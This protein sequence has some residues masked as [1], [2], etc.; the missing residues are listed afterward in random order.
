MGRF[1]V[2]GKVVNVDSPQHLPAVK[3]ELKSSSYK[4]FADV[5]GSMA[6]ITCSYTFDNSDKASTLEIDAEL[7]KISGGSLCGLR[8]KVGSDVL[9]GIIKSTDDAADS[10]D[11]AVASGKHAVLV[12]VS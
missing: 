11:D 9:V 10:Y 3:T 12:E 8:A 7:P 1:R 6:M 4:I 2:C 5:V